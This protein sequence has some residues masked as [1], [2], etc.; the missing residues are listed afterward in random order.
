MAKKKAINLIP[1]KTKEEVKD[2]VKKSKINVS[3]V[4][5][6]L[7]VVS[8]SL[9][10]L[11]LNL[12]ARLDY[13]S[14]NQKLAN[15]K[16]D[17]IALQSTEKMQKTLNRKLSTYEAV[18]EGDFS[19][20][21]VLRYLLDVSSDLSNVNS[22][23]VDEGLNFQMEGTASSYSNV[24]RLWHDMSRDKDYFSTVN[25]QYA[26][27]QTDTESPESEGSVIFAFSGKINRENLESL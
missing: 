5:F 14:K 16:S 25:L 27:K 21:R 6:V 26:R 12:Y 2:E 9:I 20:D 18:K 1:Q 19:A 24:A 3:G 13:N 22:L 11:G 23:Y 8:V 4:L 10:V 17:I 7:L 15:S